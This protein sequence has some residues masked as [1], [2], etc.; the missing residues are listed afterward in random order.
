MS[1]L[2]PV[3]GCADDKTV[4][5]Y[6][7]LKDEVPTLKLLESLKC[8]VVLPC[9]VSDTELELREYTGP[10]DLRIQGKFSIPEPIGALVADYSTIDVAIIP[11]MA[12]DS[13]GN[14]LGRG[15]GYYDRLLA[16]PCFD[17]IPLYG[18]CYDFQMLDHI[19]S[20]PHDRKVDHVIVIPTK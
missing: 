1:R 10:A 5:L 20:G 3:V 2:A 18:L 9:V 19:P 15:K 6:A 11:G 17:N 4:L 14:R 8:R 13:D 12:F 7:S 16:H